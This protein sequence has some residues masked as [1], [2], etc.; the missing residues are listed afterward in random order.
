MTSS[1]STPKATRWSRTAL[2]WFLGL[3][4]AVEVLFMLLPFVVPD[5]WYL[6][7]YLSEEAISKTTQFLAEGSAVL[8]DPDL[9]WRNRP[10]F[11]ANE[12]VIDEHGGRHHRKFTQEKPADTHRVIMLGSSM[13]NGGNFVDNQ[14]TVSA[15]LEKE[16]SQSR[17]LTPNSKLNSNSLPQLEAWNFATMMYVLDQIQIQ[18][19]RSV[20]RFQPDT[21]VIGLHEDPTAGLKSVYVPFRLPDEHNMPFVKPKF[22]LER[23]DLTPDQAPLQL[24]A[25]RDHEF[26][27]YLRQ[28]DA[29]YP[30]FQTYQHF[31]F[32][33]V[34]HH[35]S[36]LATRAVNMVS[37]WQE[38]PSQLELLRQLMLDIELFADKNG[39]DVMYLYLPTPRALYRTG[40][41][42]VVPDY[43]ASRLE[44][45]EQPWSQ[46]ELSHNTGV[47]QRSGPKVIDVRSAFRASGSENQRFYAA[48]DYHFSEQG[49]RRLAQ[50]IL[51]NLGDLSAD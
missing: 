10:H 44:W 46:E 27:E 3:W 24:L 18:L 47:P 51:E 48:D 36:A 8:A 12:W 16:Y 28:N 31:S 26:L 37:Y 39:F 6:D 30:T 43:Y 11:S 34:S 22:H 19:K 13:I 33:P 42:Q 38:H 50:V 41:W 21:L 9:G 7:F 17:E 45:L 23:G 29:Y 1:L 20:V 40:I 14:G 25:R 15:W 32:M 5:E 49:N 2:P 4:A 35:V